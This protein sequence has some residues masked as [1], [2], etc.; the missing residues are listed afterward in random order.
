MPL[1]VIPPL[2]FNFLTSVIPASQACEHEV[3]AE[4]VPLDMFLKF[5]VVV[6]LRK[7]CKLW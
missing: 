3:R 7:M 1:E 5:C 2:L 6:G 4:L